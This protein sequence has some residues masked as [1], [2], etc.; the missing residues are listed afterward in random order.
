MRRLKSLPRA[1]LGSSQNPLSHRILSILFRPDERF[2]RAHGDHREIRLR[3]K[4]LLF[5]INAGLRD[6]LPD[7]LPE[8]EIN[9]V[10]SNHYFARYIRYRRYR[11]YCDYFN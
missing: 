2:G 1:L 8:K 4:G 11:V 10:T 7:W 3:A 5:Q 9:H 6:I